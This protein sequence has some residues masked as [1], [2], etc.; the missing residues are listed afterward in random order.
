MKTLSAPFQ[1]SGGKNRMRPKLLP[2]LQAIP[3]KVYVE[4]FGGS[5]TMLLAMEPSEF[6]VYNDADDRLA[7]FFFFLT[8]S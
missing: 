2:Y 4:P 8:D 5:A 6:E 7:D 3:R 1:W